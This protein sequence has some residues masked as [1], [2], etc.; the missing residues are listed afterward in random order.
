MWLSSRLATQMPFASTWK[1]RLP[2]SSQSVAVTLGFMPGG[3]TCPVVIKRV[4]GGHEG[5][6]RVDEVKS[7]VNTSIECRRQV[8]MRLESRRVREVIQSAGRCAE[9]K[10]SSRIL[11]QEDAQKCGQNE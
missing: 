4:W 6:T 2:S 3:A 9:S 1:Q 8:V 5:T 7:N 11:L 10:S